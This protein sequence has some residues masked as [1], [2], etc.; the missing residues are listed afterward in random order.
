LRAQDFPGR[1]DDQTGSA[2][3]VNPKNGSVSPDTGNDAGDRTGIAIFW[4][5]ETQHLADHGFA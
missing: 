1:P 5:G 4:I 3:I 2:D